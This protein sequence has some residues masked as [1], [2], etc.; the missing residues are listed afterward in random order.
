VR[1]KKNNERNERVIM[2]MFATEAA[3][4]GDPDD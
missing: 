4:G 1:R 3:R 2:D